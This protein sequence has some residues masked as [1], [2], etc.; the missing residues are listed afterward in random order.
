MHDVILTLLGT[1]RPGLVEL[2]K[3]FV[4]DTTE[5]G[6]EGEE[7]WLDERDRLYAD[8]LAGQVRSWLDE[9]PVLGSTK[10][11][12]SPGD[13]LILVLAAAAAVTG[14]KL[15]GDLHLHDRAD[16]QLPRPAADDAADHPD[17]GRLRP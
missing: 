3:P 8:K 5:E 2:W 6:D 16:V 14:P 9:A 1:D 17:Q 15:V 11:P 13:I 12:L 7:G 4:A 10:R